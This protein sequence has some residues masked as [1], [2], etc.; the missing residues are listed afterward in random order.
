MRTLYGLLAVAAVVSGT[1]VPFTSCGSSSDKATITSLSV[2]GTITP[3]STLQLQADGTLSETVTDATYDVEV[4]VLGIPVINEKGD[5]CHSST[6]HLDCPL[7]AGPLSSQAVVNVPSIAPKGSYDAQVSAA[8][9][10][11][12]QLFCIQ[13]TIDISLEDRLDQPAVLDGTI[14]FINS[15]AHPNAATWTA[16]VNSRWEGLSLADAK[17]MMGTKM[18]GPEVDA[19]R[20]PTAV[21]NE[22]ASLPTNFDA[23]KNWDNCPIIGHIRDQASC[24]S[25][26]AFGSTEALNDRLC[27]A[28]GLKT[29]LSAQDT[30]SCCSGFACFGS[31]GCDGGIPSEAWS[32]F[33][34][35]GVVTGGDYDDIGKTDTCYPYQIKPCEHHVPGS[36]PPCTEGGSTPACDTSCPNS[37]YAVP[38]NQDKHH[39]T[40]AYSLGSVE[41]IQQSIMTKGP[42][43]AAFS[44]YEDFLSYKSG[45]Y[46]HTT[47]QLLGGHA[48]KIMGW[49]EEN[50][51]PYW[52]VANSWNTDWGNQGTFKILRGSDECGIESQVC[53]G[54]V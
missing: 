19:A 13:A 17:R 52:L 31:N 49:G 26:W 33:V 29:E 45:V 20:L 48:I 27:I 53:A 21:F 11:G 16:G 2:N 30:A 42:V 25:C 43:T 54:D 32:W 1:S 23:R 3:G 47:G 14:D 22:R 37:G 40:S 35:T 10:D 34:N 8:D 18:E 46:Q 51:T 24:G 9:Q 4:K 7:S 39:A 28:H 12:N 5:A 50:G 38:F 36:R 44:V 6:F 15:N 41:D